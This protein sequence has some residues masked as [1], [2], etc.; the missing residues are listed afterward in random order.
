[1]S[2]REVGERNVEELPKITAG[3]ANF[4]EYPRQATLHCVKSRL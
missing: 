1:V 2:P 3:M 4:N